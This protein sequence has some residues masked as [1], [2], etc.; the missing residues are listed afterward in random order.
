MGEGHNYSR[1]LWLY[2][3]NIT[4][5]SH[6][7]PGGDYYLSTIVPGGDYYLSTIVP[8]GDYYLSTIVPGG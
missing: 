8:G 6:F 1:Y 7:S 3:F 4:R 5:F 2:D